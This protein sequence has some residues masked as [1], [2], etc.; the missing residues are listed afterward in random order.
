V[1]K[2]GFFFPPYIFPD[3]EQQPIAPAFSDKEHPMKWSHQGSEQQKIVDR[4][5]SV[6]FRSEL[7]SSLV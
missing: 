5:N 6:R 7:E 4:R 3:R 2:P 1:S